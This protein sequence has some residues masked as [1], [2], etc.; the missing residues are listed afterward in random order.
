MRQTLK[1]SRVRGCETGEGSG[2]NEIDSE[3]VEGSGANE[4]DSERV[5]G[6]EQMRQTLKES[7][8]RSK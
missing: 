3:R 4:T 2:A 6:A 5:E 8:V 1:E 7:R